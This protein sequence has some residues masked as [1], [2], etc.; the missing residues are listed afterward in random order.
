MEGSALGRKRVVECV[1]WAR[2]P[3]WSCTDMYHN[4]LRFLDKRL[5]KCME[6][7]LASF[8]CIA[9]AGIPQAVQAILI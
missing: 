8:P 5:S 4:W 6:N 1:G 9:S 3:K 2:P 7:W